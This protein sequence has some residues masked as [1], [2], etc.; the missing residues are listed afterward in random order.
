MSLVWPQQLFNTVLVYATNS[1]NLHTCAL[2]IH[3]TTTNKY[4]L[5][6]I[7]QKYIQVCT[8][9]LDINNVMQGNRC[10]TLIFLYICIRSATDAFKVEKSGNCSDFQFPIEGLS[11]NNVPPL[12]NHS[13]Q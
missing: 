4:A 11:Y 6:L 12:K 3:M 9:V 5:T 8:C 10:Q 1:Q 7:S 13:F 2:C